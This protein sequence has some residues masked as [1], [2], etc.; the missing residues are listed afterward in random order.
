M[1][2]PIACMNG[3]LDAHAGHPG[4]VRGCVAG[5]DQRPVAIAKARWRLYAYRA[6]DGRCP[7]TFDGCI[8]AFEKRGDG[9]LGVERK[10]HRKRR[11]SDDG[12]GRMI[13]M[14]CY[15]IIDDA[16]IGA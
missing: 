3:A 8:L 16:R 9:C 12:N 7:K 1:L 14:S 2:N 10:N 11:T 13:G 5:R 6:D 15:P 4:G